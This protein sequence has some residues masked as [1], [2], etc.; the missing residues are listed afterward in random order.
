MTARSLMS[1]IRREFLQG[2]R[3]IAHH[4]QQ[5]RHNHGFP[6]K[7]QPPFTIVREGCISFL[8]SQLS[9]T[10]ILPF[11]LMLDFPFKLLH[12]SCEYGVTA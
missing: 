3:E 9:F 2:S 6:I 10:K 8:S 4:K 1:Y 5:H 12:F 11:H 7:R